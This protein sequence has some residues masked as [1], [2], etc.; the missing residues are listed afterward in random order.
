MHFDCPCPPEYLQWVYKAKSNLRGICD[1]FL[2]L[3]AWGTVI[4]A[5]VFNQ[6]FPFVL[7]R[8]I[9]SYSECC[10]ELRS[11][12]IALWRMVFCSKDQIM[13]FPSLPF[14]TEFTSHS[15]NARH[16]I[17]KSNQIIV[18]ALI[19]WPISSKSGSRTS[20]SALGSWT[21]FVS[22]KQWSGHS[23]WSPYFQNGNCFSEIII[24]AQAVHFQ[25]KCPALIFCISR[26]KVCYRPNVT[27]C[28]ITT[29]IPSVTMRAKV[30]RWS[31]S[32]DSWNWLHNECQKGIM[33]LAPSPER[34]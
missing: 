17:S 20:A 34:N 22:T 30:L 19:K 4:S 6:Q 2:W 11:R 21:T 16:R 8:M 32:V 18:S 25:T 15:R 3:D 12:F 1:H 33:M 14:I 9:L 10:G 26:G 27:N 31:C 29:P 7:L 13:E 23:W 28:P 24:R 5:H